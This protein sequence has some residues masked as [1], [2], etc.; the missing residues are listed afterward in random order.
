MGSLDEYYRSRSLWLD[1]VPGSLEPRPALPGDLD[2][3]VAII[4][5]GY[6]GLWTAYYLAAADP[7]LRIVVL[8]REIAGFGAA[9][10]NGAWCLW[11][12]AASLEKMARHAGREG[13]VAMQHAMF[14]TVDEVGR[15]CMAEGIDCGYT[16]DG[17]LTAATTPAHVPRLK[18]EADYYASW[19]FAEQFRWLEKDEADA[20]IRVAGSLGGLYTPECAVVDPA[21]LV[22]GLAE[23]VERR[24]ATIYERTPVLS[25]AG[26]RG[27]GA[28]GVGADSG[29]RI[30]SGHIRTARGTVRARVVVLATEGYTAGAPDRHRDILPMYSLMVATEPLSDEVWAEIGWSGRET[31]ADGRHLIIYASRTQDG[32]IALGGRGAP[33]HFGSAIAD[34]FEREP[35]VFDAL[36]QVITELFPATR[37]ARITHRWGGPIGISRD[38]YPTVA[39]DSHMGLG[40]AGAYAGDGVATSNL[41]GRTLADLILGRDT[42]IVRLPWVQHRSRRWEP[43]PLRWL[44]ANL[45]TRMMA[46]GDEEERRTGK[47][48]KKADLIPRLLVRR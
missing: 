20:H 22:R 45:A 36:H 8:E 10:R 31:F 30:E 14:D 39:Y 42:D 26:G 29:G 40:R 1:G 2:A 6:T 3:D 28:A 9:G 43:E 34:R 5:A 21:R 19:G 13:A 27:D 23:A 11:N 18:E 15:V 48:S 35:E 38:W 32:R 16:K 33:Y 46:A 25:F 4:G 44:G 12:F 17:S 41:A 24:G 7:S 47:P 37:E